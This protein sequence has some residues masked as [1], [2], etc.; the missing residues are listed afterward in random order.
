LYS[1]FADDQDGEEEEIDENIDV[2]EVWF[3]LSWLW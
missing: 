1:V 2:L 3:C